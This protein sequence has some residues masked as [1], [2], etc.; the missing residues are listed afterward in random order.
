MPRI[1]NPLAA[2]GI[3]TTSP[4]GATVYRVHDGAD[5][6]VGANEDQQVVM[7]GTLE[8][9]VADAWFT[10]GAPDGE[11]RAYPKADGTFTPAPPV[12]TPGTPDEAAIRKDQLARDR[13]TIA[14]HLLP[15]S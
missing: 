6:L 9:F 15:A 7:Q 11:L 2:D 14:D 1:L 5:G 8:G 13:K 3:F 12:T 4:N 10:K